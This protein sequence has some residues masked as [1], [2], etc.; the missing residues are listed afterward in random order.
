MRWAL[1]ACHSPHG[2][3]V[4]PLALH[5][6]VRKGRDLCLDVAGRDGVAAGEADP[7]DSQAL[8]FMT[9]SARD[10]KTARRRGTRLTEVDDSSL[11][12]VVDGLQLGN[13][14]DAA[15]HGGSGNEAPDHKIIQGLAVDRGS[16]LLLAAEVR[17]RRLG[18]PHDTVDVDGHDLLG[19]LRGAVD[20][21][22]VLP[23]D[24]RVGDE[25]V[26]TAV[27]FLDNLV[28]SLVHG[29]G[30]DDVDLVGSAWGSRSY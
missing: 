25:D 27:E 22:T 7:L 9:K 12:A 29:V 15:A 28:D 8:A 16:L 20:E 18:A 19:C 14:H 3:L 24:A 23:R 17:S 6:G 30:R 26:Q 10:H 4:L 1:L 11:G 5:V 2:S 13:V 21:G